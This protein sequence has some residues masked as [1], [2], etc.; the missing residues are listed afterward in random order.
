[1]IKVYVTAVVL[2]FS[3][4]AA[5]GDPAAPAPQILSDAQAAMFPMQDGRSIY[6]GVCQACHMP[7]G[8]GAV[9]AGTYP[10]LAENPTLGASGY[11][12]SLIIHGQK[13][14]PPLGQFLSDRQIAE[15]V[16]Y[17]RT[18]FGNHY[19]DKVTV[20]DVRTMR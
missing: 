16:N 7:G 14:M 1:M 9:G 4:A 8:A 18:H 12:V 6:E 10:P 19:T 13:A 2:L 5:A 3:A 11:L 17:I 20:A 15:V